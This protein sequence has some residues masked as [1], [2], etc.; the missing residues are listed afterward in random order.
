[1]TISVI[2]AGWMGEG[3][4]THRTRYFGGSEAKEWIRMC[5]KWSLPDVRNNRSQIECVTWF[6]LRATLVQNSILFP[7]ATDSRDVFTAIK[8]DT[9]RLY[10]TN[11]GR[12]KKVTK[13]VFLITQ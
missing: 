1:M 12:E 5:R 10:D 4:Q 7:K 3:A 13:I 11:R 2:D 9:I 8:E 6:N